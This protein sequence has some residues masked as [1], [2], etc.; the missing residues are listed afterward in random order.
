M[1]YSC[2]VSRPERREEACALAASVAARY[3]SLR[4][5][6]LH[7]SRARGDARPD[8]DW[9]F[10]YE[11]ADVIDALALTSDLVDALGTDKVDLVD[12]DRAGGLLRYRAARDAIIVHEAPPSAYGRFWHAAVSFWCDARPV[13]ERGYD[14]VLDELG[15]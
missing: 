7:G 3:P 12:L 11:A 8:S 10:G 2:R 15:P 5:L 14:R 13:L 1:H 6:V 4:L 9:D